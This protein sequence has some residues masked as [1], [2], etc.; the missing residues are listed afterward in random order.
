MVYL[1]RSSISLEALL[2]EV[3]SLE[4]GGTGRVWAW[5]R[6]GAAT[7]ARVVRVRA[8]GGRASRRPAP[9]GG[10][11]GMARGAGGGLASVAETRCWSAAPHTPHNDQSPTN[12]LNATATN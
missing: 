5:C 3:S 10:A 1:T 4:C 12:L 2:A 6:L 11:G 7:R 8:V 9:D